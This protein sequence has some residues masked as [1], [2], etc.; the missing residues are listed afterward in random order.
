MSEHHR[1]LGIVTP[2]G[3]PKE[4]SQT[5]N[6]QL[7]EMLK[8]YVKDDCEWQV[9]TLIDPLTGV[10]ENPEEVFE[11]GLK[12][13]EEENWDYIVCLTDL[14]FSMIESRLWLKPPPMIKWPSLRCQVLEPPLY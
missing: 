12:M 11:A 2:P 9:E 1:S 10:T 5:I 7:P 8:Y 6:K 3:Y 14:P 4:L 13:R